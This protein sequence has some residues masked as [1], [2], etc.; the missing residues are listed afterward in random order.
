MVYYKIC[1]FNVNSIR[2]R[3][4]LILNWLEKRENDIDILCFQETKVVDKD[5]P[6][7]EFEDYRRQ[8]L[9]L[10]FKHVMSAPLVRSS[11]L[12]EQGYKECLKQD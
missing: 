8:A 6:F 7:K 12:A 10:G 11:F 9:G 5:F 3:K 4:G 1:T 2:A